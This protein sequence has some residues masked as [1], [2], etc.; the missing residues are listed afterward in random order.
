M[1]YRLNI[2]P[3]AEADALG[4]VQG[5]GVWCFNAQVIESLFVQ[6]IRIQRV[7]SP[8]PGELKKWGRLGP[9]RNRFTNLPNGVEPP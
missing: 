3:E 5:T 2:R 4:L 8:V 1:S 6:F 7:M 9:G